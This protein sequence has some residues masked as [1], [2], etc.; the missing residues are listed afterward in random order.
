MPKS[1]RS[2]LDPEKLLEAVREHFATTSPE[3]VV[4]RAEK[5]TPRTWKQKRTKKGGTQI[6]PKSPKKSQ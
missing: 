4:R 5:L 1:S 6:I 2:N 3:E